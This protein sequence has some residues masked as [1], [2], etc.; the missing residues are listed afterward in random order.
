MRTVLS[1]VCLLLASMAF[2]QRECASSV[3]TDLQKAIDPTF[4][5]KTIELENFVRRQ[6]LTTRE[7]GQEAPN[8]ITI[9]VVVHVLYKTSTQNISEEQIKTQIE[10]LNRD[11]RRKNTDT[12]NTPER[13]K[14]FAAD[15]QIEFALATADPK[16]RAT[17]GIVRKATNVIR[18]S[19]DDKIKFSSQGGDDAWDSRY[20]LN[21]WIGDLGTLLGY[22]SQPGAAAEKDGVVVNYTTFGTINV[23]APYNL[24]RTA[25]HEVGH[26][27][28]LKH[29]WGESYCGDDL[30]GDTPPQGNFTSGC[31]NTF[32]SSCSNG[33]MGDMYMNYMDFTNDACMN[34]FTT[35]QKQRMLSF[36]NEGG[37][38]NLLLLSKGLNQPWVAESPV[39]IPANTVFK[40]YPNP[41]TGELILNFEYNA[42]WMG[43][44]VSIVNI[45]GVIVMRIQINSKVQKINLSQLRSGMYFI[46]AEN[47]SQKLREKFIKL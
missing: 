16:G 23:S 22:S 44:T 20:Y 40:I 24:G 11:F 41:T 33:E 5:I 37:P 14:S 27:L 3:Y 21:F 35:G 34:L 8:V 28:G 6:K 1:G 13:F 4:A 36:F 7:S 12:A 19:S 18:W 38:R 25:T 2:A 43:K 9:P 32:R 15:V 17:N 26:W 39:E 10:A 30:V 31:P 45:E 29:I 47:G 46:Q 42:D